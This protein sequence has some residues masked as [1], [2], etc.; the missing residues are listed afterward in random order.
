MKYMGWQRQ[1]QDKSKLDVVRRHVRK[2]G[3]C[4]LVCLMSGSSTFLFGQEAQAIHVFQEAI[5]AMRAGSLDIAAADFSKVAALNPKFSE[6]YFNLGLVLMQQGKWSESEKALKHS[7]ALNPQMKGLNL[8][9]GIDAYRMD[10]I[11]PATAYLKHAV[12]ADA[13]N[14]D[15]WMWLGVV[16]LANGDALG[17]ANSLDVAAKLRPNDVD[18]LYHRGRAHMLVSKASYD[19]MYQVAPNSW[20]VHQVLAESFAEADRPTD[21]INECKLA[22]QMRPHE[23]GLHQQL[24]DIYWSQNQ[25]DQAEAA[26]QDELQI[27]PDS[28]DAMYKLGVVSM[29]KSKPEVAAKLLAEV[30]V[31]APDSTETRYQLGRAEAQLGHYEVAVKDFSA[32]VARPHDV[33]PETVRQ[34]YYQLSRVYQHLHQAEESQIALNTFLQLKQKA[35]EQQELKLKDKM[36]RNKQLQVTDVHGQSN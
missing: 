30:L 29:E 13:G 34:A 25:L 8:F 22:I 4:F 7:Q 5:A 15:A 20:R 18:I 9:L 27:D 2:A 11:A 16:Q 33:D 31:R 3:V 19:H 12:K 36:L 21:A 6:A 17:A 26:Y 14:A 35:D 32:V 23:P 10:E 28:Y 1:L 24:G